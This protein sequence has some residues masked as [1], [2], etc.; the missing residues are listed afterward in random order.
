MNE[1]FEQLLHNLN[2]V[3]P[4]VSA[5]AIHCILDA[6]IDAKNDKILLQLFAITKKC[7]QTE[8]YEKLLFQIIIKITRFF[9]QVNDKD[10]FFQMILM[11]KKA[12]QE[13]ELLRNILFN[14]K[15]DFQ[16]PSNFL[17]IYAL[18][19]QWHSQQ[20][21]LDVVMIVYE[22]IKRITQWFQSH[23]SN[24]DCAFKDPRILALIKESSA[25]LLLR[26]ESQ[27]RKGEKVDKID[28]KMMENVI[29]ELTEQEED[30]KQE[31]SAIVKEEEQEQLLQQEEEWD[32]SNQSLYEYNSNK[33]SE[34]NSEQSQEQQSSPP[35]STVC[36]ETAVKSTLQIDDK[37]SLIE[38][39]SM[40]TDSTIVTDNNANN[41]T[42]SSTSSDNS[43]T[44]IAVVTDST[45]STSLST[46]TSKV[47]PV[48]AKA[49]SKSSHAATTTT[50][51]TMSSIL[52]TWTKHNQQLRQEAYQEFNSA[53]H[54]YQLANNR[55][56]AK[57]CLQYLIVLSLPLELHCYHAVIDV[58]ASTEAR[59]YEKYH[60]IQILQQL[61]KAYETNNLCEFNNIYESD[62]FL[63]YFQDDYCLWE[64]MTLLQ[65]KM[66]ME[67][68]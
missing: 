47:I 61:K 50:T 14:E 62:I 60:E 65:R 49:L 32:P 23:Y 11:F 45:T 3:S 55:N 44:T 24:I 30:E 31:Q 53:F 56:K 25:K 46:I 63:Q 7:L 21:D 58:T 18:E 59:L 34:K 68:K 17:E 19:L 41:N 13:K 5:G 16:I 20:S 39:D 33:M 36:A 1:Q 26:Q 12:H 52:Q 40:I 22:K 28:G 48:L 15:I 51:A 10:N 37:K 29:D 64:Q 54:Y 43:T 9:L 35:L 8:N 57:E 4:N 6:T 42:N 66:N 2:T 67:V 38:S 27:L